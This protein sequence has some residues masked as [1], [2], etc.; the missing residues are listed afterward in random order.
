MIS[1]LQSLLDSG[2]FVVCA[3]LN[4]PM[5]ANAPFMEK[6]LPHF[7]GTVDAVNVT[8][9]P[10]SVMRLSGLAACLLLIR[11][12]LEPIMQ[13]T[14]RDKNRLAL[15]SEILGGAAFGV[16]NLLCV[17]GDHPILGSIPS[18]KPVFDLDS[19][20]LIKTVVEMHETKSFMGQQDVKTMPQL[21]VGGAS[22]PFAEPLEYRVDRLRKKAEAGANFVQTQPVF[23]LE[24]FSRWME[25]VREQGLHEKIHIIPGIMPLKSP[26]A[27]RYMKDDVPGVIMP[28]KIVARMEK[29]GDPA[30]EGFNIALE[31]VQALRGVDGVA[32]IHL[33]PVMWEAIIP[34]IVEEAG[35]LPRPEIKQDNDQPDPGGS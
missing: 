24:V 3:E 14:C 12:G 25:N 26:R 1:R 28:D 27:A 2:K 20:S 32:G 11:E 31:T 17:T 15:G 19:V 16:R 4:P 21:F 29:A 10:S 9:N 23:D 30:E 6:R 7:R 34:R 8:D 35:L 13:L 33:M 5:S 22:N 18:A